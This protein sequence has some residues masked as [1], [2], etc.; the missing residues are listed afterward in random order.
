MLKL[1]VK[2]R[3]MLYIIYLLK[4]LQQSSIKKKMFN[5]TYELRYFCGRHFKDMGGKF[6]KHKIIKTLG[7]LCTTWHFH[8]VNACIV[9]YACLIWYYILTDRCEITALNRDLKKIQTRVLLGGVGNMKNKINVKPF[10]FVF[11]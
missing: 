5:K 7:I 9:H 8:T 6:I 2:Q 3:L 11:K 4:Y 10:F 1:F